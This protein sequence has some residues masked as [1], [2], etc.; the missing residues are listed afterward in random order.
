MRWSHRSSQ[1]AVS[2]ASSQGTAPYGEMTSSV[3]Q[4]ALQKAVY[5]GLPVARVGRGSP[6]GF[7]DLHEYFIAG[8]N[9]TSTKARMLLMACLLRFGSLPPAKD[10]SKP[11]SAEVAATKNAIAAYQAIFHTH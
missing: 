5:S 11:T 4:D 8:S 2:Q 7:A 6:E 9:L 10:P 1:L 3:R